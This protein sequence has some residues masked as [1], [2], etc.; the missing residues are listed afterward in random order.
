MPN[1]ALKISIVIPAY[2]EEDHL[3]ACL[4]AV[5]SQEMPFFE[6]IVVDNNSTDQTAAIACKFSSVKLLKETKIG[7]VYARNTAMNSAKGDIIARI[8][9]DTILQPDWSRKLQEIFAD[10]SI[11]AVSGRPE[12]YDI[13]FPKLA[14]IVENACRRFMAHQLRNM[15]FLQG[16]NMAVRRNA[17]EMV[18]AKLCP[19]R[20]IHEDFDIAIHLQ[21]QNMRV[22][23]D[24]NLVAGLSARCVDV[25]FR[26]FLSYLF[27]NSRSYAVHRISK[28]KRMYPV[29][30][31][32]VLL[33]FPA[34]VFFRARDPLTG[35]FS[36]ST[37]FGKRGVNPRLG[38]APGGVYLS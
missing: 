36:F 24:K 19:T 4:H 2:N 34:R 20:D 32:V 1:K 35:R 5:F 37:L 31:L 27:M 26:F 22:V 15:L 33:F 14:T 6:V 9:A 28:Y 13:S 21:Q 38:S 17:W 16:A 12:F 11:A 25:D 8:D 23:Y 29:I 18:R 30:F 3:A 7:K 10:R